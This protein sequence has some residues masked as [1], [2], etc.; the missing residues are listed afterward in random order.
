MSTKCLKKKLSWK[1]PRKHARYVYRWTV[2]VTFTVSKT[3][4][5][6]ITITAFNRDEN[7]VLRATSNCRYY[8]FPSV[9]RAMGDARLLRP[10]ELYKNVP[11]RD[12]HCLDGNR[13]NHECRYRE[14]ILFFY[15][16]WVRPC[17]TVMS[18]IIIF[19]SHV[20]DICVVIRNVR[21]TFLPPA[22]FFFF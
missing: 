6:V 1:Y 4:M 5:T 9:V 12:R 10:R 21:C 17:K 15:Q 14:L 16:N 11:T 19:I 13:S 3:T 2:F 8:C 20:Y 18:I 7:T 22:F